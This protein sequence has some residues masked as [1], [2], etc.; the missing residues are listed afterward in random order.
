MPAISPTTGNALLKNWPEKPSNVVQN[1]HSF[2]P[3]G[4]EAGQLPLADYCVQET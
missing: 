2:A 3:H 1:G 4:S